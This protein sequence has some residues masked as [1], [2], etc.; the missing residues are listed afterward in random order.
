MKAGPVVCLLISSALVG[1]SLTLAAKANRPEDVAF[2][3]LILG[4]CIG[5]TLISFAELIRK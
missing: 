1:L 3:S 5:T 2:S 4:V